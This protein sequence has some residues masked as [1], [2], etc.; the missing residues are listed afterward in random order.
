MEKQKNKT[1][2][3][4]EEGSENSKTNGTICPILKTATPKIYIT[5]CN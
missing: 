4:A 2:R 3:K 1:K 5:P